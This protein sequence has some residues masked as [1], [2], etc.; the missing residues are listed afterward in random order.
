MRSLTDFT[1]IAALGASLTSSLCANIPLPR[2]Y[3][4]LPSSQAP[5]LSKPGIKP[6][7]SEAAQERDLRTEMPHHT[8]HHEDWSE[9]WIPEHCLEEAEYN[10]LSGDDFE[11]RTVRYD[12]CA[13]PW[14]VCRH[15]LARD[16][17]DTILSTLGQV[18]VGMRQYLANLVILPSASGSREMAKA[19]AYTRGAVMVFTPSHFKLGVIFH[20][21]SH[22]LDTF[23]LSS[24]IVS[25]GLG[26]STTPFSQ[27]FLWKSAYTNDTHVPTPY[28]RT[29]FKE[30][31]ADIGRWTMSDIAHRPADGGL[32]LYSSGWEGC[33]W[34]IQCFKQFMVPI[35]FTQTGRCTGKV[36]SSKPV[37]MPGALSRLVSGLGIVKMPS[38]EDEM[39]DGDR[40][41]SGVMVANIVVPDE[42]EDEVHVYRGPVP[43]PVSLG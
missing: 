34:Q 13:A 43:S 17:W 37:P 19:A 10:N 40:I 36:R 31:F 4:L 6:P 16:E 26:N 28:A 11:V 5:E 24:Y 12:D 9:Y 15:R 22:I 29:S 18:P 20:E 23:S 2:S 8:W 7:F 21:L 32:S 33:K 27:T 35:I 38:L 25:Q 3:N 14:V 30:D 1:V 39:V 42:V 41:L